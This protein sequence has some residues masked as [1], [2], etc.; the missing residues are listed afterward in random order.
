MHHT[1]AQD[2]FEIRR[3]VLSNSQLAVFRDEADSVA[4]GAGSACVRHLRRRSR[5]FEELSVSELQT[6]LRPHRKTASSISNPQA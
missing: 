1:L 5:I 3:S 4:A 2:G 6:V